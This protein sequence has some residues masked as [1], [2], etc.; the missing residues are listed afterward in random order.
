MCLVV[1]ALNCHP[2]YKLVLA[3][4][5]D[6]FLDR[7]TAAAGFWDDDARVLGGRDLRSGGTWL[8]VTRD[9][10]MAAVTNYRDPAHQVTEP[11]S[12]GL[13]VADYLKEGPGAADFMKRL[14]REGERYNGFN[15]I[16]GTPHD[17]WYASN[18]G[19][20]AG[21]VPGGIHGL[22][23]H[24]LDTPWPKVARARER[25]TEIVSG[26]TVDPEEL[27]TLMADD[28][29]FTDDRLPRTGIPLEQE[30]RLSPLFIRGERYGTRSTTLLLVDRKNRV[31]FLERSFHPAT[32]THHFHI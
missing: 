5:R 19:G 13:L 10:R 29:I 7:P 14:E 6:E 8:G 22:S 21:A 3:A 28:T 24:L 9:G 12:R 27:F 25:M 23:N 17:L 26:G 31:C 15:L 16:F 32:V 30:R 18:R 2:E 11:L 20:T 4:N 1:F